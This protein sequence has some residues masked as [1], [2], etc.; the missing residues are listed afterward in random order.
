M[1]APDPSIENQAL[2]LPGDPSAFVNVNVTSCEPASKSAGNT[3]VPPIAPFASATPEPM[4][5]VD[6][7]TTASNGEPGSAPVPTAV[8]V[9]PPAR[10]ESPTA[11]LSLIE[12]V[13]G[14]GDDATVVVVEEP[15]ALVLEVLELP[16]TL[17]VVVVVIEE[18][19]VLVVEVVEV[20]EV[21]VVDV[22]VVTVEGSTGR[23]RK[24]CAAATS[25]A[26]EWAWVD[27]GSETSK[28]DSSLTLFRLSIL[29]LI[30][31]LPDESNCSL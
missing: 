19:V 29:R 12:T 27:R 22:V 16:G 21:L 23:I 7:C 24:A 30:Q 20:V 3:N 17:D 13:D 4:T 2:A 18:E 25:G 8:I 10:N 26:R 1:T 5:V 28:V 6:E 31:P 9:P 14:A 11:M 15:R